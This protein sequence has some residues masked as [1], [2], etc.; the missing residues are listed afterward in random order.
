MVKSHS[1][2]NIKSEVWRNGSNPS[3]CMNSWDKKDEQGGDF[4]CWRGVGDHSVA[5]AMQKDTDGVSG[6]WTR[7]SEEVE[8]IW[9]QLQTWFYLL[10]HPGIILS[11]VFYSYFLS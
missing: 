3:E 1:N 8:I 10:K 11:F 2:N 4:M 5:L 9:L 6:V 7:V